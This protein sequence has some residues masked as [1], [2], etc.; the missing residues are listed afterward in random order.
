LYKL[1]PDGGTRWVYYKM[2]NALQAFGED[3]AANRLCNWIVAQEMTPDGDFGKNPAHK[4]DKDIYKNAW[5]VIGCQRLGRY[6]VAR[7][8]M[9]F[10]LRF[11]DPTSG[12]F[13]SSRTE[14]NETTKQ[15]LKVVGYCGLAAV[16]TGRLDISRDV[17]RWLRMLLQAQPCFPD[18]LYSVYSRAQGLHVEP[19]PQDRLRYV[20][21][22]NSPDHEYFYQLGIAAAF[23]ARLYQAT[24][25]AE[26]LL[27]AKE[28]MRFAEVASEALFDGV[29]AGKV[30]WAAA[31]LYTLTGEHKYNRMALRVASMLL[32]RQSHVGSWDAPESSSPNIDV[33]AEMVL[34]LDEIYQAVETPV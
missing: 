33:S 25:E 32:A 8:G 28:Y 7:K 34:W 27:L 14:Q 12:G 22:S 24:D 16:A 21:S 11:R 9:D 29:R 6:E 19:D 3:R 1:Q 2:L 13:Y 23:L 17:G 15:D 18:K 20:V 4:K 26:W 30:G 10:I 5:T 31:L